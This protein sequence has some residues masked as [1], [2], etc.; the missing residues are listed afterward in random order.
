MDKRITHDHFAGTTKQSLGITC[1]RLETVYVAARTASY[2]E[3]A[4]EFPYCQH[5]RHSRTSSG[6]QSFFTRTRN[7]RKFGPY[8]FE[9]S[10]VVFR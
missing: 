2:F 10:G 3:A 5:L 8:N 4:R 9:Y 6:F 7:S 1:R